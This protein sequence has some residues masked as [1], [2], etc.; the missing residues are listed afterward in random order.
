MNKVLLILGVVFLVIA[1]G[2]Y[3]YSVS[4]TDSYFGGAIEDTEIVYPY[5]VY[6]FPLFIGGIIMVIISAVLQTNTKGG[7]GQ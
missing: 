2:S 6:S 4:E 7:K 1:L 3:V 5:R